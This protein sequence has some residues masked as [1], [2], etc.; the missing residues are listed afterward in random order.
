MNW[1][2]AIKIIKYLI[3]FRIKHIAV[4]ANMV[5]LGLNTEHAIR[6]KKEKIELYELEKWLDD[7]FEKK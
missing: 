1:K 2:R 4:D 5:D 6:Y 3:H 7:Q